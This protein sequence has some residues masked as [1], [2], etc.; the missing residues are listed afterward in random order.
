[1]VRRHALMTAALV[2][3][4]VTAALAAVVGA[5][6]IRQE[7]QATLAEKNRADEDL[8]EALIQKERGDRFLTVARSAINNGYLAVAEDDLLKEA[9]LPLRRRLLTDAAEYYTRLVRA[10]GGPAEFDAERG[11]ALLMLAL[12]N[13]E[14]VD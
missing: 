13:R 7:Q 12:V 1:G 5:A 3:L 10:P 14:P 8:A 9:D 6:L 11:A 2:T 4:S